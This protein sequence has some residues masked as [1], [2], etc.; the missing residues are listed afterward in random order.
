MSQFPVGPGGIGPSPGSWSWDDEVMAFNSIVAQKQLA[1]A[2]KTAR[3]AAGIS[4]SDAGK[5]VDK[6]QPTMW[7][8]ESA[9][10]TITP[11]ELAK[12]G[13]A[14]GIPDAELAR[15]QELLQSG[16]SD[17]WWDEYRLDG[18]LSA[19]YEN[20]I[21][22]EN[23]AI[24]A[25]TLQTQAFQGLLQVRGYAEALIGGGTLGIDPDRAEALVDIR[26]MRQR[27]LDD[28]EPIELIAILT[29]AVLH[30]Q[31][32]S[33]AI[34]LGQLRHV[35][36]MCDHPQV[37]VLLVPYTA[38]TDMS[39]VDL[40]EFAEPSPPVAFMESSWS[41][42]ALDQPRRINQTRRM[43]ARV[44]ERALTPEGT[45]KAIEHKIGEMA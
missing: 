24:R 28:A 22:F 45:I 11:Q 9:Q 21:A 13:R 10:A 27:R 42:Q 12:L 3:K 2:L 39:S 29:E 34:H 7:R 38:M 5:V 17:K 25:T 26:M 30:Y 36:E 4:A 15:L 19:E 43:I 16:R 37:T 33:P 32:G 40:L 6:S 1:E 23:E 18:T 41:N 20:F 31:Y 35:R 8:I 14:Y 44:H